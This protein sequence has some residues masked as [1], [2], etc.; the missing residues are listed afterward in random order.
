MKHRIVY[1]PAED[2]IN[3]GRFLEG[4]LVNDRLTHLLHEDHERIQRLFD[5]FWL[6]W[7][8]KNILSVYNRIIPVEVEFCWKERRFP[9]LQTG[10][11]IEVYKDGGVEVG[12]RCHI[13]SSNEGMIEV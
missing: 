11:N 13:W 2:L 6:R 9:A 1:P 4:A 5:D 12:W 7:R 10:L 3:R 8:W